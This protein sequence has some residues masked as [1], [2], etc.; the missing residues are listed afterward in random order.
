MRVVEA[1]TQIRRA[2]RVLVVLVYVR[3]ASRLPSGD[4]DCR[5]MLHITIVNAEKLAVAI[6]HSERVDFGKVVN[7]VDIGVVVASLL[8]ARVA[9]LLDGVRIVVRARHSHFHNERCEF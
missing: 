4:F 9:V 3:N 1:Q 7:L 5:E 2:D 6:N 8:F